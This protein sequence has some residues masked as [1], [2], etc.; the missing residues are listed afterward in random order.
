LG[1][2]LLGLLRRFEGTGRRRESDEEGI[3]LRID[4]DAA[5]AGEGLAQDAAMRAPLCTSCPTEPSS[6]R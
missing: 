1:Q 3:T 5:V 6:V 2:G 4:L